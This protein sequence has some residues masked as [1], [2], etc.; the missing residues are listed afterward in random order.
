MSFVNNNASAFSDTH[1]R[2]DR[3][4]PCSGMCSLCMENCPG[5]C[6]I[7]LSAVLGKA[8]VYPTNTG[9]NQV[10]GEKDLPIDWSIFNINGRCFGA[11]GAPEN[12]DEATI[13]NVDLER[14]VGRRNPVK[15]AV[16]FTLPAIIKLN[17]K[18]YFAAAAMIGTICVIGEGCPSKDPNLEKKDGKIVRFDMLNDM[19]DAFRS[20]YRGYGQIAVQCNLEDLAAGLAEFAIE[21]CGAEAIEFK[22]GQSA[23]GTQP[24]NRLG[25]WKEA[26]AKKEDGFI[27]WPDPADP[28]VIRRVESGCAPVFWSYS[29]LPMWTEESLRERIESLRALGM[30]NVYFKTAG[31]DAAD[32]ERILRIASALEVDMVTFDGA[33]GGSGY[34]PSKMMNEFGL[35]AVCIEQEILPVCRA[36]ESEGKYVPSICITGGFSTEDQAFKALAYGAPYVTAVGLCRATMA[37]AMVGQ[38]VGMQTALGNVPAHLKKFG[39]TAEE[40]FL[41]LPE[42]RY[43]YGE[44][45]KDISL[46][47]VGAFSY[48]RKMAFGVQ[49]FAALNRKFG[50]SYLGREDLIPMTEDARQLMKGVWNK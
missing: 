40:L 3:L 28:E 5:T 1:T 49:H 33:G 15:L 10:A 17:W 8:M 12:A 39:A 23:K 24:A 36:L 30:K 18:D 44:K 25:S 14:T 7:G 35:P 16:P 6:E 38:T 37:A 46:G 43:L 41:E 9:A 2:S 50:V 27:V 4:T 48:L 22:F 34:S 13:F 45:A 31:F 29:R 26:L 11:V 47:A 19:L 21:K 20:H 32:L 42:V